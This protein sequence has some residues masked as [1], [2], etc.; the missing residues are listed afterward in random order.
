[1]ARHQ[2]G[3]LPQAEQMY[4]EVL[5]RQPEDADALHCLGVLCLQTGRA[6]A[7]AEWIGRSLSKNPQQP[8][9]QLN[10]G[11]AM[12]QLRRLSEALGCF[13]RA[14][15][16][17]P[18]YAEALKNRADVL[19]AL[20]RPDEALRSLERALAL[21]PHFPMALNNRGNALRELGRFAEALSSYEMALALEPRFT[22]ALNNRGNA[23]R[24]LNRLEEA[25]ASFEQA[26]R[27]DPHYG[28]ALYNRGTALLEL[29]KYA[30]ALVCF[31]TLLK[32][33][34]EDA[35]ALAH[36]SIALLELKRP[37]EALASTDQALRLRPEMVAALINRASALHALH[38][39]KEALASLEK[40][41]E[42][43]PDN[44]I[45]LNNH[46]NT[47]VELFRFE[48]GTQSF[49]RALRHDPDNADIYLN[50]A[51]AL[52]A[53]ER[54][55]DALLD[56]HRTLRLK[57][58]NAHALFSCAMLMTRMRRHR[59][60]V[61]YFKRL[62]QADPDYPYARGAEF[63]ARAQICDWSDEERR[64][65]DLAEEVLQGAKAAM[66]F[67]FL[68]V[69]DSAA[70]QRQCATT[71]A[72][73]RYPA[74]PDTQRSARVF[75]HQRIRLAYVSGDLRNHPVTHLIV[76]AIEQHDR[77]RFEIIAISFKPPEGSRVGQRAHDAFDRFVYFGGRSDADVAAMLRSMEIDIAVDLAGCTEGNRLGIFSHRAAPVQ[78]TYLGYAGTT[79]AP[80]ID[81]LVA[82]EVVVPEGEERWYTEQVVRLPYCY[83]PNDDRRAIALR[84][85]RAEV[86]L[87][88]D[89]L[90]FCAF[91]NAYKINPPVFDLWMQLLKGASGSVLWLREMGAEARDNLR[92][93]ANVR[94]VDAGRLLFAPRVADMADHLAR[95]SLA[96]LFL[97][98]FPYNAHSTACDALWSGVPVITCAGQSFASRVAASAISAMGLPELIAASLEDYGR[99]ALDLARQPEHLQTLRRRLGQKRAGAP[100]FDTARFIGQLEAAYQV[101]HERA[102]RGEPP[103]GFSVAALQ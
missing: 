11:V 37:A 24:D 50:R 52:W 81:Y 26:L 70:A 74:L 8:V 14:L 41:L 22:R 5:R 55:D 33:Q 93:E 75:Q 72:Q 15:L 62:R 45:A 77:Q 1:M 95:Q 80:Y 47:L 84:P 65:S 28:P 35:D 12:Q 83:L 85:T 13:E 3:D 2:Q 38:K 91:T 63:H 69:T 34:P 54:F 66:P 64:R 7:A 76:G 10:L 71:H 73:D 42:L 36:R 53:M 49:A 51:K 19:L 102:A 18:D 59:E 97:D 58:D 46:G 90:V 87:P 68:S 48:E 100:L 86:G 16:L 99:K 32:Q 40:A 101:M 60:A 6:Q 27:Q 4:H 9:A 103:A 92:R 78:A 30:E 20:H 21:R 56:Y 89:A 96:D 88:E 29:K 79:G 23:L 39:P 98:T 67:S 43:D 25:L 57:P 44:A 17:D 61:D 31:E 94:G 82:D